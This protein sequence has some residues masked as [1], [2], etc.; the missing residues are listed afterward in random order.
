MSQYDRNAPL[1]ESHMQ[2][3]PLLQFER[4]LADAA[5]AGM[6]EP[7]AMTLSTVGA[8]GRPSGRILLYKGLHEGGFTFYTNY[9]SRKGAE[10][11]ASPFAAMTFWWDRLERQV[12]IEG[13]VH[14]LPPL[15]SDEYFGTRPRGS[16]LGAHVSQQSRVVAAREELDRRLAQT[17]AHFGDG[18]IPR[19]A[20]WGGYQLVPETIEFWQGR[21]DRLHDRLLYRRDVPGWR[22]ERLEP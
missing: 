6:R 7:T 18:P 4:W 1:L 2:A 20:H 15:L 16:Q 9:E 22:I 17:Q 21:L 12:R 5:G 19:P 11:A 10:L 3:D 8:D 13:R 14:R